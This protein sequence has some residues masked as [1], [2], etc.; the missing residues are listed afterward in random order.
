MSSLLSLQSLTVVSCALILWDSDLAASEIFHSDG[1][2]LKS[3]SDI[4]LSTSTR[5]RIR[6]STL[7]EAALKLEFREPRAFIRIFLMRI[8]SLISRCCASSDKGS[9]TGLSSGVSKGRFLGLA[10]LSG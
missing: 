9:S 1:V 10:M 3:R 4:F 7:C 8:L 6:L 5:W 2:P